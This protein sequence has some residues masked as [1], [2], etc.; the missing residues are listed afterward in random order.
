M[1]T[2]PAE[3]TRQFATITELLIVAELGTS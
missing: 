2:A 1:C 3:R